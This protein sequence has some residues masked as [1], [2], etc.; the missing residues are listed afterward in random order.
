MKE[1]RHASIGKSVHRYKLS[2]T[3]RDDN[4]ESRICELSKLVNVHSTARVNLLESTVKYTTTKMMHT[5]TLNICV[6]SNNINITGIE[7][8]SAIAVQ[9]NLTF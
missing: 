1:A 5:L 2:A 4:L 9:Q 6:P 8:C 3:H 7:T